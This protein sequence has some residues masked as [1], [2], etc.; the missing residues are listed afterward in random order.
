LGGDKTFTA[1][2]NNA[3]MSTGLDSL[4]VQALHGVS[5][6]RLLGIDTLRQF[7]GGST[8]DEQ[9][10]K[11]SIA[12]ANE[13]ARQL[14][15][16]VM[17]WHHTGKSNYRDGVTDMYC[18]SGSAAIADNCRFVLLLQSTTWPDIE[19]KVRRTGQEHGDPL[20]LQ[21]TRGSLLVK[22]PPPIYLYRNGFFIG[23]VAG[24]SLTRD[25]ILDERDRVVLRAVR[26]G[27]QSKNAIAVA[28]G[29]KKQGVLD[30]IDDL[31]TRGHLRNGS[32]NGSLSRPQYVITSSGE[33]FLEF[34]E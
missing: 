21:S 6:L 34:A 28:T 30:R 26:A 4:I 8:N 23:H 31:E 27:A 18:G 16:A 24:A 12:G 25:Q 14:G 20:V 19:T 29:G 11:L 7:S 10:M 32:P 9:V 2:V 33:R 13:V 22:A 15:C 17:M 1:V 3:A 5:D